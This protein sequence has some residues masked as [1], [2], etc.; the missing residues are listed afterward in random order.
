M[1]IDDSIQNLVSETIDSTLSE[2]VEGFERA[3]G[4]PCSLDVKQAKTD[5]LTSA[6]ASLGVEG[7][8]MTMQSGD[9][10]FL[11]CIIQQGG[12][13]PEWCKNPDASGES[14]MATLSQELGMTLIPED[15]M[16]E[17]FS[18]CYVQSLADAMA[19]ARLTD[20]FSRIDMDFSADGIE[21][22]AFLAW[23][24]M[25]PMDLKKKP[26]QAATAS[27]QQPNKAGGA[28]AGSSV[29]ASDDFDDHV[30][31]L[32]GF[33]RSL[34]QI[35]VPLSV[36]VVSARKPIGKLLEIGPGSILQFDKNC[37][38]PLILE[39]NNE[40][41]AEGTAVRAGDRFGLQI[42]RI[43]LPRERFWTVQPDKRVS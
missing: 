6:S 19:A 37:E 10:G 15:Y 32:P 18:A 2:A 29:P 9:S 16:P 25:A 13:L 34:L 12:L 5:S 20:S 36:K 41:I 21:T 22:K 35:Q 26:G 1:P 24:V 42:T 40:A 8:A 14:R 39:A 43:L 7:L 31:R 4:F 28:T 27:A 3:F 33:T 11:F 30:D 38:Q 17:D 23:P